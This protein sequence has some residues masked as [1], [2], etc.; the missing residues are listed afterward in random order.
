MPFGR[1]RAVLVAASAAGTLL[2]GACGS[3]ST[4]PNSTPAAQAANHYNSLA[5]SVFPSATTGGDSLRA[6]VAVGIAGVAADGTVP[7]TVHLTFN[8]TGRTW[9][10]AM[11]AIVDSAG[12]DSA[13][14]LAVWSDPSIDTLVITEFEG[15][16]PFD[17]VAAVAGGDLNSEF[18]PSDFAFSFAA[19]SGSCQFTSITLTN[20][21]EF[22]WPT[23]DPSQSTC[24]QQT[25]T[26]Q[27]TYTFAG[28]DTSASNVFST[29]VFPS[30]T[31][32]GT[33]LAFTTTAIAS[34][35]APILARFA[36][37]R[38]AHPFLR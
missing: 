21:G 25:S 32:T 4:S 1:S 3:D 11:S 15:G 33:R 38:R 2:L 8:G 30:Q 14:I 27:F 7:Q 5:A 9:L 23:Y 22:I 17:A 16:L 10:G 35:V 28:T 37:A 19:P 12:T 36:A 26:D 13:E 18:E 6:E 34:R 31:V 20:T 24:L 29:V